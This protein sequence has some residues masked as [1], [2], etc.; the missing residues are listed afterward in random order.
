MAGGGSCVSCG[1]CNPGTYSEAAEACSAC[2]AGYG[3]PLAATS[4]DSCFIC[5]AGT[6][7]AV[8]S[9]CPACP[10]GTYSAEGGSPCT[11]C[12]AGKSIEDDGTDA[13]QH[14]SVDDCE[15][16]RKGVAMALIIALSVCGGII[17]LAVG[18]LWCRSSKKERG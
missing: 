9:P 14:D 11:A 5:S 16:S 10:A 3:S 18:V 2:S 12:P 6:Y 13:S 17:C 4:A 1:L 7:S 15:K 8:G